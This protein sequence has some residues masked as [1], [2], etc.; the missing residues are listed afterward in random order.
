MVAAREAT[1]SEHTLEKKGITGR[2]ASLRNGVE[3]DPGFPWSPFS[4]PLEQAFKAA[5]PR[6]LE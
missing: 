1:A 6:R 4:G 2:C 5:G 3:T